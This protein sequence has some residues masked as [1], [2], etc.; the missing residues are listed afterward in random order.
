MKPFLFLLFALS[1]FV[2]PVRAALAISVPPLVE[3]GWLAAR[4]GEPRLSIIEMSNHSSFFFD[5]HIPGAEFTSKSV[6]REQNDE[7][8]L[9]RLPAETLETL[10]RQLGV[11]NGDGVVIYYKG[12]DLDEVL[13]AYYL[14]WL[15]HYLGHTNVGMLDGGWHGWQQADGPVSDDGGMAESGD[16][17]ARPL[18]ALEISTAEL[19]AIREHYPVIDG[20]PA[21]HFHGKDKFPAN[22]RH[23]RIPDSISQPWADFLRI[24]EDGGIYTERTDLAPFFEQHEIGSS[25]PMLITCLGGTGAAID[26]AMFYSLGYRNMRVHDAG[27]REWNVRELPLT[28]PN[29]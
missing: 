7:G 27:L 23:G 24:S 18:P 20:R 12:N 25:T 19:N 2:L 8:T 15:L 9:I 22:P 3:P 28:S 10:F 29:N 4:L 11:N 1:A 17:V 26:Y 6:W 16:F 14:F 5:G 13:G 21:T